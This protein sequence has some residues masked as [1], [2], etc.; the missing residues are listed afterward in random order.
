LRFFERLEIKHALAY[1]RLVANPDDDGAL[2]RVINFPTRGIGNRS[3]EQ[4]QDVAASRG[5]SLWQAACA[6]TLSGKPGAALPVSSG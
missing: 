6:N 2:L 5:I 1:L 3:I 4:L